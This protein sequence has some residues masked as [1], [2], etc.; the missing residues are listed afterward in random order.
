PAGAEPPG[1]GPPSPVAP[2]PPV[3]AWF[4]APPPPAEVMAPALFSPPALF[5]PPMPF[6]PPLALPPFGVTPLPPLGIVPLPPK[7]WPPAATP[8]P[9]AAPQA[10]TQSTRCNASRSISVP[11]AASTA[12]LATS[13]VRK[14]TPSAELQE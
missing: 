13:E 14:V 9:A 2:P 6:A 3:P 12:Q 4:G 11:Q 7:L 8:T 5:A 10:S 1:Q